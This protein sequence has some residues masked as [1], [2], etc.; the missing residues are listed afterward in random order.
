MKE[1]ILKQNSKKDWTL[2]ETLIKL[3]VIISINTKKIYLKL[4]LTSF[5]FLEICAC[6]IFFLPATLFKLQQEQKK[7]HSKTPD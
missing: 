4:Y 3:D 5:R 2:S 6:S 1:E 7:K